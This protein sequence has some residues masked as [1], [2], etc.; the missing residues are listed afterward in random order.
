MVNKHT[1]FF[2]VF[3]LYIVKNIVLDNML[4]AIANET[5]KIIY[6]A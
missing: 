2:C 6:F 5:Y 4:Y 3:T 1:D